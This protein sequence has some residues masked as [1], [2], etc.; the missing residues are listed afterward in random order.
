MWQNFNNELVIV[1]WF[2][3]LVL[4][5]KINFMMTKHK[6][7]FVKNA[8]TKSIKVTKEIDAPVEQVWDAWT[9]AAQLDKWWA[10]KPW[11]A[12]TKD[13]DF[14]EG[15][16]WLYYMAGPKGEK[17]WSR[18]DYKEIEAPHRFTATDAFTDE[19][20]KRNPDMPSIHWE[21]RFF[22][23]GNAMTVEADLHFNSKE[24]MDKILKMG[25]EE[26]FSMGLDQLE[27]LL[28]E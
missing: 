21:V 10:P 17:Q 11:N 22:E 13:L 14:R 4:F 12:V 15:G 8:G 18:S 26:G 24:E 6:A 20:G 7:R 25:F 1:A 3:G 5:I 27:E 2:M 19:K 9:S 28:S 23:K 16:S